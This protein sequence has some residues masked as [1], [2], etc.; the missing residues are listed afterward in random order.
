MGKLNKVRLLGELVEVVESVQGEEEFCEQL[1]HRLM[2]FRR[3]GFR[4]MEPLMFGSKDQ[5]DL[6]GQPLERFR[7]AEAIAYLD[8]NMRL[9]R[10]L[11]QLAEE[12][13]KRFKSQRAVMYTRATEA[14]NKFYDL[15]DQLVEGEH[16]S[17]MNVLVRSELHELSGARK[18]L[19]RVVNQMIMHPLTERTYSETMRLIKCLVAKL[20]VLM[21]FHIPC[22]IHWGLIRNEEVTQL[23]N[24][25]SDELACL[26]LEL[27][28]QR[29]QLS[30]ARRMEQERTS[31]HL[32]ELHVGNAKASDEEMSERSDRQTLIEMQAAR[33]QQFSDSGYGTDRDSDSS[34]TTD[35]WRSSDQRSVQQSADET[36]TRRQ[37]FAEAM[38]RYKEVHRRRMDELSDN[39]QTCSI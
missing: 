3:T 6:V 38:R 21:P 2:D 24:S 5:A 23:A 29:E 1:Q 9:D 16:C 28:R 17:N 10:D 31:G 20:C 32:L 12:S 25:L 7:F 26:Q 22:T 30:L 15:L 39:Q 37:N 11:Y 33:P 27:L 13:L 18:C 14:Q 19:R 4:D 8:Q 35:Q 36:A 34:S